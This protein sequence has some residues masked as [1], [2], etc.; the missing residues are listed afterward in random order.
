MAFLVAIVAFHKSHY[1][2]TFFCSNW[3]MRVHTLSFMLLSTHQRNMDAHTYQ[4]IK[5]NLH[6]HLLSHIR[7]FE[8][9]M[10]RHLWS[11]ATKFVK[12]KQNTRDD[13]DIT[14]KRNKY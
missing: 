5:R 7:G 9:L 14:L 11:F 2:P 4:K 1:R 13:H 6:T 3:L 8:S 12:T 10:S